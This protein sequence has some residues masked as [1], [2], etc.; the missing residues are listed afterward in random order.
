MG[1]CIFWWFSIALLCAA[2]VGKLA[3]GFVLLKAKMWQ[4]WVVGIAMTP[5]GE[6]GLIFAE[7]GRTNKVFNQEIY[8]VLIIVIAIT[9]IITPIIFRLLYQN[10]S[11]G[12][13]SQL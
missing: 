2:F 3:S 13:T 11:F 12:E 9:T 6:V 5:R 4:K 10:S 7:I 8:A 1:F